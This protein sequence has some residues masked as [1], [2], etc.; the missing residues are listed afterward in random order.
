M[1][2]FLQLYSCILGVV[3][4]GQHLSFFLIALTY[5]SICLFSF[6]DLKFVQDVEIIQL[7]ITTI[8]LYVLS[9]ISLNQEFSLTLLV[10]TLALLSDSYCAMRFKQDSHKIQF[11][12]IEEFARQS[13]TQSAFQGDNITL[14]IVACVFIFSQMAMSMIGSVYGEYICGLVLA[15]YAMR[16]IQFFGKVNLAIQMLQ[17]NVAC[18]ALAFVGL[19]YTSGQSSIAIM[20]A[21]LIIADAILGTAIFYTQNSDEII[22]QFAFVKKL[23]L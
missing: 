4:Q 5:A 6:I 13:W 23:G 17:S 1:V 2:I 22:K 21:A 16:L 9:I 7:N 14:Q 19:N 11:T 20:S 15:F 3:Y 18:V 10:L 12:P 8:G